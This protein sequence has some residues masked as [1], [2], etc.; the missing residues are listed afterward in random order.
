M[1]NPT[2][3]ET[4][5]CVVGAGVVGLAVAARLA[6]AGHEVLVLERHPGPGMEISS[7]NSEVIHAGIYYHTGSLKARLCVRGNQLLYRFCRELH[8]PYQR[9]GKLI[10]ATSEAQL[11]DLER[12]FQQG[13]QNGAEGLRLVQGSEL[14]A[15]EPA[16]NAKA[17]IYSPST[18][19]VDSHGLVKALE[20]RT[21]SLG[22]RIAYTCQVVHIEPG[23]GEGFLLRTENPAGQE[24]IL[25]RLLINA[26]GLDSDHLSSMAGVGRYR[27]SWC[28]GDYF[29]V[30]GRHRG[31]LSRL[32]YPVPTAS[33]RGLGIHATLDLSGHI[34]LGPDVTYL[35][36]RE[37][38]FQVD[39]AKADAFHASVRNFLPFV[40]PEDLH[41]DTAGIRPKLQGPG[42]P[43]QDFVVRDEED[44][45]YPGLI[46][47][48]GIESP[49]LTSC[50]ALAE[51]VFEITQQYC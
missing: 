11:P 37:Q 10:V 27:L 41:P 40:D 19:I 33:L 21:R 26:A 12:L 5:I 49:G 50:L 34:R 18:G 23:P 44:Q 6:E 46:N 20:A 16:V 42:D 24:T 39:P 13:E 30:S 32:V 7:R 3:I 14:R 22:G 2:Y 29:S 47:L 51:E 25:A 28:K 4:P 8:I 31:R 43:W 48:V 38:H 1:T 17:A 45:G 35:D 36:R 9:L 15:M